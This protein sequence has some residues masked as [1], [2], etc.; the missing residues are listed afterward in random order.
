[1]GLL[2]T[3]IFHRGRKK[4]WITLLVVSRVSFYRNYTPQCS[5]QHSTSPFGPRQKPHVE[6]PTWKF[7]PIHLAGVGARKIS[8]YIYLF[9][10]FHL[11]KIQRK[12]IGANHGKGISYTSTYYTLLI[13]KHIVWSQMISCH[14]IKSV[15]AHIIDNKCHIFIFAIVNVLSLENVEYLKE[16]DV[17]LIV[18][19]KPIN[20]IYKRIPIK[21]N[22][23][24]I[25]C[26][27]TAIFYVT[28]ICGYLVDPHS[29]NI[30]RYIPDDIK[31][32]MRIYQDK[33][34]HMVWNNL[35]SQ[36]TIIS[37]LNFEE[38]FNSHVC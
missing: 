29:N 4:F 8:Q 11:L 37:I 34:N 5:G 9:I 31:I 19:A 21:C 13:C 32:L 23:K 24:F 17:N 7:H 3:F 18:E 10:T 33:F 1:M 6:N 27:E 12:V 30:W 36:C 14:V 20:I 15:I 35:W 38:F 25:K 22:I 16:C 28:L 2:Q 26:I